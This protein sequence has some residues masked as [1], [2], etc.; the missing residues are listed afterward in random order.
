MDLVILIREDDPVGA[1][2]LPP[3]V[4]TAGRVPL[5]PPAVLVDGLLEGFALPLNLGVPFCLGALDQG[6]DRVR[7]RRVLAKARDRIDVELAVLV[8]VMRRLD[9]PIG[10]MEIFL[11]D[12]RWRFVPEIVA[13]VVP[14]EII[15]EAL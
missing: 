8:K 10:E 2:I 5:V 13:A 15:D 11:L 6:Q 7:C 3:L 9:V 4:E 12:W 14:V 1:C